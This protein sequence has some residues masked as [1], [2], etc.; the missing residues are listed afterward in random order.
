MIQETYLTHKGLIVSKAQKLSRQF[1]MEIDDIIAQGNLL[2]CKCY[3]NYKAINN[4][5]FTTYL[6]NSLVGLYS[7]CLETKTN[8]PVDDTNLYMLA[9]DKKNIYDAIDFKDF[10]N[11]KTNNE[12]ALII[13]LVNN[14]ETSKITKDKIK[15][16]FKNYYGWSQLKTERHFNEIYMILK[17]WEKLCK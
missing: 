16:Y 1:N 6:S 8:E 17:E 12:T 2:F 10:I 9:Q 4:S 14:F 3:Y 11:S 7:Y 15:K 5:S 13:D